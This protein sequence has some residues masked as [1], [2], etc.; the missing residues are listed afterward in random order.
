MTHISR[1]REQ[2][3]C[4]F[5][6]YTFAIL[7]RRSKTKEIAKSNWQVTRNYAIC[8]LAS[9]I[10]LSDTILMLFIYGFAFTGRDTGM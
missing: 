4:F 10:L 2:A 6:T 8:F 5:R 9:S 1:K 7:E 3:S